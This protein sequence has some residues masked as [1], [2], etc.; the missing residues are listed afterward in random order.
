MSMF[1]VSLKTGSLKEAFD[2]KGAGVVSVPKQAG[3][4]YLRRRCIQILSVSGD[5]AVVKVWDTTD[6][7]V[8]I[9]RITLDMECV[10][11]MTASSYRGARMKKRSKKKT[12]P[13]KTRRSKKNSKKKSKKRT[14]R[15][16]MYGLLPW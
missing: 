10:A 5:N 12:R 9:P 3:S 1:K 11:S 4:D 2:W 16:N 13:R 14:W 6:D 15:N 8:D 7:T